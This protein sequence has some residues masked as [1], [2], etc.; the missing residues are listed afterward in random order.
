V[1]RRVPVFSADEAVA[2]AERLGWDVVLK[3]TAP[4]LRARPDMAHVWRN[5]DTPE[6][7]R[8][9]W[10]QLNEVIGD[11]ASA[12]FVVQA[13]AR[14]GVPLSLESWEDP[15]FGPIVSFG[16][17]GAPSELLGDRSFRIPPMTDTDA[18]AMVREI[19]SAPLLLGYRGSEVVD[20][21]VVE[22]MLL[23]MA[24]L[25]NDLPEVACLNLDLVLAG[26]SGAAV[27]DASGRVAPTPDA[28][29]DT[30]VRRM[31]RPVGLDDT[32]PG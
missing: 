2:A 22:E 9:A 25:K 32:D 17:Q 10:D 15:L 8:G 21:A 29:S 3:A 4:H 26:A 24:Q 1:W 16:V 12:G 18:A 30:L 27:L 5:I 28:R 6:H 14:P 7:M 19:K 23:R 31:A 20:V 13:M 11:S